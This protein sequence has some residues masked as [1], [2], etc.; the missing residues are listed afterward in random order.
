MNT[1]KHHLPHFRARLKRGNDLETANLSARAIWYRPLRWLGYKSYRGP[2]LLEVGISFVTLRECTLFPPTDSQARLQIKH[3]IFPR[4]WRRREAAVTVA[5]SLLDACCTNTAGRT[6]RC[7]S[8]QTSLGHYSYQQLLYRIHVSR[9]YN[10]VS[11]RWP[12]E[13]KGKLRWWLRCTCFRVINISA[14][15]SKI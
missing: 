2:G 12:Y 5:A 6:L 8:P 15:S 4:P 14:F 13:P 7:D 3:L 1:G 11:W 10:R 9:I